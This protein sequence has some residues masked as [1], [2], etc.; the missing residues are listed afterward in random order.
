MKINKRIMKKI[1]L[2]VCMVG[3]FVTSC[4]KDPDMSRLDAD[5]VVYTDHDGNTDF[6]RFKTYFFARQHTGSRRG[7]F[8]ILEG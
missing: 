6:G 4:E 1:L 2:M 7:T 5:L 3:L 8:F